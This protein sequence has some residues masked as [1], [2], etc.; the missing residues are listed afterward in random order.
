MPPPFLAKC[1][2]STFFSLNILFFQVHIMKSHVEKTIDD[3]S[4]DLGRPSGYALANGH[5]GPRGL[6]LAHLPRGYDTQQPLHAQVGKYSNTILLLSM[7]LINHDRLGTD[8]HLDASMNF[9]NLFHH[10]PGCGELPEYG[11]SDNDYGPLPPPSPSLTPEIKAIVG[12][13]LVSIKERV[14]GYPFRKFEDE[15]IDPERL[16]S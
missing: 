2:I 9:K 12:E 15:I 14:I 6:S 1:G 10:F 5:P 7:I 3:L 11:V 16:L 13:L 8:W 4:E